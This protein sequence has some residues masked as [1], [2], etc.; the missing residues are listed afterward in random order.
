MSTHDDVL[1]Q[2]LNDAAIPGAVIEFDPDE[3]ERAGAFHDD[4]LTELEA[5]TSSIDIPD[6]LPPVAFLREGDI[7]PETCP[8]PTRTTRRREK[9]E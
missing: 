8:L 7:D 6:N 9:K 3:A 4:A 2:K 5:F 1:Q